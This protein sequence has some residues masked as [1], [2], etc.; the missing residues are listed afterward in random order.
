MEA[1]VSTGATPFTDLIATEAIRLV[2]ANLERAAA[3]G[4]D[5][6]ARTNLA[7]ASTLAGWAIDLGG[8]VVVHGAGHPISGRLGATHAQSLAALG[9]AF[10]RLNCQAAPERFATL[11]RLLGYDGDELS[12][13]QVAAKAS[14]ALKDFQGRVGRDITISDLGVTREMIP[15]LAKDA[16]ETMSGAI[17]NNPRPLT[18]ADVERLYVESL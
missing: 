13:E 4:A 5:L 14:A 17:S 15:Q 10:M 8:T 9:V 6:E 1:Y 3:N 12:A 11:A 18:V 2:V 7:W 16:F